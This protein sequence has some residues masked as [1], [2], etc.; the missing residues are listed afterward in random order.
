MLLSKA[1]YFPEEEELSIDHVKEAW[2]FRFALFVSNIHPC[3]RALF[4]VPDSAI[5]YRGGSFEKTRCSPRTRMLARMLMVQMWKHMDMPNRSGK[6]I[7]S[8]IG[9]SDFGGNFLPNR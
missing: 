3:Y 1:T 2:I 4:A 9:K 6:V 5:S 7:W 8:K